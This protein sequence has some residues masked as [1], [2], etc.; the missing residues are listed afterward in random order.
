MSI[1]NTGLSLAH[2]N[3]YLHTLR[4]NRCLREC[5]LVSGEIRSVWR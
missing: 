5:W 2:T 4:E 3:V 1:V